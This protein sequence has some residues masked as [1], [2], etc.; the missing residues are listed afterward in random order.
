MP[1]NDAEGI[2]NM[3]PSGNEPAD[4]EEG[5]GS[6]YSE[7]G[8]VR[9][10]RQITSV[11]PLPPSAEFAG[12]ESTFPGAADR[13]LNMAESAQ[14]HNHVIQ[15][16]A[17]TS[18]RMIIR[19]NFRLDFIGIPLLVLLAGWGMWSFSNLAAS[20]N[21]DLRAFLLWVLPLLSVTGVVLSIGFRRRSNRPLK[22]GVQRAARGDM[23]RNNGCGARLGAGIRP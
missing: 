14:A 5:E 15:T 12:Y 16:E 4:I 1:W 8:A 18:H 10:S 20:N 17:I 3:S 2:S 19:R 6:Q 7:A 23:R 21:L 22:I 9:L 11:S 13:I